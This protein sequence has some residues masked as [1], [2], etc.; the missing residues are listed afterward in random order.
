LGDLPWDERAV[1][2]LTR[3]KKEAPPPWVEAGRPESTP[4]GLRRP[5]VWK[6]MGLANRTSSALPKPCAVVP[7]S[8]DS[9]TPGR[10][11][12]VMTVPA[13]LISFSVMSPIQVVPS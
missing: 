13:G 10:L 9:T 11:T 12:S 4:R 3:R 8:A 5:L 7:L 6:V 2:R 1:P